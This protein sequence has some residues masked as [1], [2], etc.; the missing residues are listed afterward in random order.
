ME[1]TRAKWNRY[2]GHTANAKGEHNSKPK[3]FITQTFF[4]GPLQFEL[5]K[6]HCSC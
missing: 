4:R 6:F 3:L 1:H 2:G 5:S